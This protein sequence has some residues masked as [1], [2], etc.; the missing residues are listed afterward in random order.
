[1]HIY[2]N[3][4]QNRISQSQNVPFMHTLFCVD[5]FRL[6]VWVGIQSAGGANCDTFLS[7]LFTIPPGA[8]IRGATTSKSVSLITVVT[9][10]DLCQ[11]TTLHLQSSFGSNDSASLYMAD[12]RLKIRCCVNGEHFIQGL[13]EN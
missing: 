11:L 4:L 5:T 8:K 13:C 2:F 7:D 10:A 3:T 1:M 9:D 12:K 6:G